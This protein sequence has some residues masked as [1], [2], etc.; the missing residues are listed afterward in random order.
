MWMLQPTTFYIFYRSEI[1]SI[2]PNLIRCSSRRAKLN[3]LHQFY[4]KKETQHGKFCTRL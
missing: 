1:L 4:E 3:A 2:L